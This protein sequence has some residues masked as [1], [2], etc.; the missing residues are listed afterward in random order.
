VAKKE[1]MPTQVFQ[2]CLVSLTT[3]LVADVPNA[4]GMMSLGNVLEINWNVLD[5][6]IVC[7]F[8]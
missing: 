5:V 7:G 8:Q 1:Q 3:R 2:I 6:P 4:N